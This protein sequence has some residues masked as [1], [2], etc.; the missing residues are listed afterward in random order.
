M[1]NGEA[2]DA[3]TATVLTLYQPLVSGNQ[4]KQQMR[5]EPSFPLALGGGEWVSPTK[6]IGGRKM[7]RL[8]A[9]YILSIIAAWPSPTQFPDSTHAS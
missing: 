4:P 9:A 1:V 3:T 2:T 5:M 8:H 7:Q 6:Y